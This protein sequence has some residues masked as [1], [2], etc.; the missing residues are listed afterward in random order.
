[1]KEKTTRKR[2]RDL[3][4]SVSELDTKT[5]KAQDAPAAHEAQEADPELNPISP[6]FNASKYREMLSS[7]DI[8]S[9]EHRIKKAVSQ[10]DNAAEAAD[11]YAF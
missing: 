6:E 4:G 5:P 3:R 7:L 10:A 8:E 9:I 2:R 11:H 1:M